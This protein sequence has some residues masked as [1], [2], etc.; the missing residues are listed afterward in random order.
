M[1]IQ[2]TGVTLELG[3]RRV[4]HGADFSLAPG[5]LVGLIGANGAGK[6]S[7]LRVLANLARPASGSVRYDGRTAVETG[8]KHLARRVAYLAQGGGLQWRM[9]AQTVVALGRLPHLGRVA[10]LPE[11]DRRAVDRAMSAT[12]AAAFAGRT[13]DTLSGGERA[14]VLL[15]R[16]LAVEAEALL[17]DEPLAALDPRHQLEMLALL[18]RTAADGAGVVC[19]LHDLTLAGRFCD[20]LVLLHEG[21]VLRDG[22]P[23]EVLADGPLAQAFGVRAARGTREGAAYVLP[24]EP[25][26]TGDIAGP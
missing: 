24:W 17:A 2:A 21:R 4:L 20:R 6:T 9:R 26:E 23:G 19:V 3:G 10:D 13:L 18:R 7:L 15:A 25:I 11:A 1:H 22:P 8:R 5:E 14:R 16:A 12:G